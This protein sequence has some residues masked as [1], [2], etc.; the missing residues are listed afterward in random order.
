MLEMQGVGS[1]KKDPADALRRVTKACNSGSPQGCSMLGTLQMQGVQGKPDPEAAARSF[2]QACDGGDGDG[3][4]FYG[5]QMAD[6]QGVKK[7]MQKGLKLLEASCKQMGSLRGCSM[8]ARAML[9]GAGGKDKEKD[10]VQLAES[11]CAQGGAQSCLLAGIANIQGRGVKRNLERGASFIVGAC[12]A[13][14]P[15]ACAMQ[16]H[17]PPAIVKKVKKDAAAA[18]ERMKKEAAKARAGGA[19]APGGAVPSLGAGAGLGLGLSAPR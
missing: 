4:A 11:L 1:I 13:G 8:Y 5:A 6:G 2:K 3:C 12:Q 16:K 17:L 18:L 15:P 10:G 7:D 9:L 14:F 19:R